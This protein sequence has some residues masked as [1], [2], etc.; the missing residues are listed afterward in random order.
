MVHESK[1]DMPSEDFRRAG[2]HLVDWIAD[3]LE[4]PRRYP[5]AAHCAPGA[6]PRKSPLAG[7]SID[8]ILRDFEESILPRIPHWNHPRFHAWFSITSSGPG[9]LGELLT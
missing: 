2:R 8:S 5:V 9:V 4:D 1:A 7:D 3:Y 6:M